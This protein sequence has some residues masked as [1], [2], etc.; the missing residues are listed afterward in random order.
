MAFAQSE[1]LE[2]V[3]ERLRT[4][5]N[6]YFSDRLALDTE[7]E[8]AAGDEDLETLAGLK[9]VLAR[10]RLKLGDPEE[11]IRLLDEGLADVAELPGVNRGLVASLE[12]HLAL[13]WIQLAEDQNCIDQHTAASCLLPVTGDG[14]HTRPEAARRAGDVL[15]D[16]IAD[17]PRNVQA[18]W[19][20]NVARQ[21]SGDWPDKVPEN[22]RL[23]EGALHNDASLERWVDR[24]PELGVAAVDLAG[25]A[26]MD[27][28]DGD[29]LL[30]LVATTWDPC[31]GMKAFRNDGR[32]GFEDVSERWGLAGQ[33]GGLNLV[34]ADFDGDGRLDLLVLRGAWMLGE[35]RI[36]NSLLRNELR[37]AE[38]A[39][40]DVTAEAGLAEPAYATGT[41]A[42]ADFDGD[43]DLDVYIG[44]E[45]TGAHDYPSQLFRN[46]GDGSFTDVAESAGVTND[47]Y[48]KSTAWGDYDDDGDPGPLRLELR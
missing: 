27:D 42:W 32:G 4:G 24:A 33:L 37:G 31:D 28:F 22:L 21:V 18:A 17:H 30:D 48:S 1:S 38:G 25:G 34:Q 13:A 20:L 16:Y 6:L 10:E 41:A 35:G 11:A 23:P 19:L 43:G 29:G 12:W 44:N 40:I 45:A 26:V 36:R 7:A 3:C 14:V 39:F 2:A 9:G 46:D 8:L 47:R 5:D 15:I